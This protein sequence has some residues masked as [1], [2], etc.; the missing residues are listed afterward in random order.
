MVQGDKLH[1][2]TWGGIVFLLLLHITLNLS[3]QF[4][5][6]KFLTN[7]DKKCHDPYKP[8]IF[9]LLL[10]YIGSFFIVMTECYM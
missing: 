6:C 8:N 10:I 2:C 9:N 3:E 7:L 5:G 1:A 4:Y